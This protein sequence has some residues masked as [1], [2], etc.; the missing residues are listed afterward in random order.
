VDSISRAGNVTVELCGSNQQNLPATPRGQPRTECAV[1]LVPA[2]TAVRGVVYDD[3]G[4]D[5]LGAHA[6][7]FP[8]T[9]PA[10]G[11]A[12]LP[13]GEGQVGGPPVEVS[14]GSGFVKIAIADVIDTPSA[15]LADPKPP[16]GSRLHVVRYAAVA[17]GAGTVRLTD[18][19][20]GL[21]VL[22]DRGLLIPTDGFVNYERRN[23]PTPPEEL[24]AGATAQGCLVF[25]LSRHAT[26]S[27][28]VYQPRLDRD[29]P[30]RWQT[31]QLPT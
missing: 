21:H 7:L 6:L 8:I 28:V 17:S 1:F 22:D 14:T 11:P 2:A 31:W 9:L 29:D 5:P 16:P 27:R 20:G 15:Y 13:A 23:C 25:S 3:R 24:P 30:T 4:I 12:V 10:T 18:I 19:T 26:I